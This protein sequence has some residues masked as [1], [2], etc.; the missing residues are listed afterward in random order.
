MIKIISITESIISGYDAHVE[1][2]TGKRFYI[3]WATRPS[4]DE[5]KKA[6][7]DDRRFFVHIN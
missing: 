7:E 3:N 1:T 5:V 4:E 2:E 6:W